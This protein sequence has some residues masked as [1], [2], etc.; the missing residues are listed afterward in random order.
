MAYLKRAAAVALLA[1]STL[2]AGAAHGAIIFS[3]DPV[4]FWNSVA[5]ANLAISPPAQTRAYAMINIA[6]HD[7]V[8]ATLGGPNN[9]YLSGVSATGGDSRAAAIQ[10]AY[11][12]LVHV[13]GGTNVGIELALSQSLGEIPD[14][15]AKTNGIA[16]GAAYA[17]A[18]ISSRTGDGSTASVPYTPT[19]L[20]G[21]WEPT[22]NANAP[23]A[24][25]Q[26]GAVNPFIMTTGSQFRPA[27]PPA[28]DSPEYAAAFNEVREIGSAGSLTRTADQTASATFWNAASAATW[29]NIGLAVAEDEGLSTLDFARAFAIFTTALADSQ[30]AGFDAKY[31]HN[32]WRPV[33][34]IRE[35][36][37]DGN[38]LTVGDPTWTPLNFAPPHPSYVSTLSALSAVGSSTLPTLFGGDEAVCST[39]GA[40]TRCFSSVQAAAQDA[41]DSRLWGGIHYRFDSEAGLAMGAGIGRLSLSGVA[42]NAVPEP[43]TWAMLIVGFGIVG[44]ALRAARKQRPALKYV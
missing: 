33:T 27:A 13:R 15:P 39:V 1:S 31:F 14:S 4:L 24:L 37:T 3:S 19:G 5:A 43:D 30:I 9:S 25:T 42:F 38:P 22:P 17:A 10:A 41:A 11:A 20:P 6:V 18:I 2:G 23:A 34:A 35:G 12:V 28:L 32:L 40:L 7:A 21:D 8:N 29:L 36:D 16:T 26:W 44:G